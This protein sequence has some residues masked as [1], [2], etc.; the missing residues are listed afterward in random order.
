MTDALAGLRELGSP[1][2]LAQGLLDRAERLEPAAATPL[3]E[4][5]RGIAERLGARPVLRRAE[6][7]GTRVATVRAGTL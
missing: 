6:R 7:L 4:E 3:I 5:A 2:H 1:L